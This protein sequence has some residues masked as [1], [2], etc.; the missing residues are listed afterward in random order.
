MSLTR[1][2]GQSPRVCSP[3][4]IERIRSIV[5]TLE[6]RHTPSSPEKAQ[7]G[8]KMSR[9][10]KMSNWTPNS[11]LIN[12]YQAGQGIAVSPVLSPVHSQVWRL[13]LVH[14]Y[15]RICFEPI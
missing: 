15:Q 14:L 12:E 11:L 9:E 1:L 4:L 13:I 3:A 10:E 2:Q 6:D 8:K 5:S 7:Q